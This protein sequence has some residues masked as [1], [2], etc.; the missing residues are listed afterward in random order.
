[1]ARSPV[2]RSQNFIMVCTATQPLAKG[3]AKSFRNLVTLRDPLNATLMNQLWPEHCVAPD[4]GKSLEYISP[5]RQLT[6]LIEP[7]LGVLSV[8]SEGSAGMRYDYAAMDDC[9]EISNSSTPEMREKTQERVDM[10]REL[11]NPHSWTTYVGTPISPGMGTDSDPG[12][13]YSVLLRREEKNL[14]EGG[15]PKLL[16]AICPAWTVKPGVSK[17]AWDPNLREDEVDLLFPGRLGFRY[18]MAKLKENLATDTSAKIFRQQS[19]VSW[20]PD[21]ETQITMTFS[22]DVLRSRLRPRSFFDATVLPDTPVYMAT[23]EAFSVAATADFTSIA[24]VRVQVVVDNVRDNRRDNALVVLDV[25]FGRWKMSDKIKQIC[26][27]IER[28]RPTSWVL[29]KDRSYE[30][31]VQG[32]QRACVLRNLPMPYVLL[33]EVKNTQQAKAAKIK[34]LEAPLVDSRLWF[35]SGSWNDAAIAQFVRFD[36]VKKS[37]GSAGSKDDIPD[38]IALA[39]Q[40]WG[41]RASVEEPDPQEAAERRREIEEEEARMRQRHFYDRMFGGYGGTRMNPGLP[42]QPAPTWREILQGHREPE[43]PAEPEPVKPQDP[44]MKVFGNR[45]PWR[46]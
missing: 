26:D 9:A 22:E 44:R 46:L 42:T 28:H 5:F 38:S 20:V 10:L 30:E 27:T 34:V 13:L 19:L 35:C 12:D 29:E 2:A 4:E 6:E 23:D 40:I 18:L 16:Y 21:D 11:G 43:V 41:P 25:N 3:F 31:L 14:R 32:V 36:G 39:Y 1:V 17:K 33:R 24:I 15:D 8:I 7:T 45:G 37:G